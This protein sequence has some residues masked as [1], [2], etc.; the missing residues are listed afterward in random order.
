MTLNECFNVSN[1]V[2]SK[3]KIA[4]VISIL[5]ILSLFFGGYLS[6]SSSSI[7]STVDSV[8]QLN[9]REAGFAVSDNPL[10]FGPYDIPAGYFPAEVPHFLVTNALCHSILKVS[11]N[12]S[13][14]TIYLLDNSQFQE[15]QDNLPY[16]PAS[17]GIS[18]DI[19]AGLV[20][21]T[22]ITIKE[23]GD[24]YLAI[25]NH[26]ASVVQVSGEWIVDI[27]PPTIEY[28]LESMQV[29]TGTYRI[30]AAATDEISEID[31]ISLI[32][33][34][35]EI[36]TEDGGS[37]G[38]DWNTNLYANGE[39]NVTLEYADESNNHDS[40]YIIIIVS[41]T[42]LSPGDSELGT[43]VMF[44]VILVIVVAAGVIAC[45]IRHN[46]GKLHKKRVPLVPSDIG[47]RETWELVLSRIEKCL[48]GHKKDDP[49]S[50]RMTSLVN[51][52]R[53]PRDG[54]PLGFSRNRAENVI[55]GLLD[56]GLLYRTDL[57]VFSTSPKYEELKE[58]FLRG[59]EN[60]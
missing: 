22:G 60:T 4:F 55:W 29:V 41:N 18:V 13:G 37:L 28:N 27:W 14:V 42:E 58:K 23:N 38:Y 30:T 5:T 11:A 39:H 31:Y 9:C 47:P 19:P 32:V 59:L 24:Y 48:T 16:E 10:S 20:L 36:Y 56:A 17:Y 53:F 44:V 25:L 3:R 49:R 43:V 12:A 26:G 57:G 1:R 34:G 8:V 15:W 35:D 2:D 33:D 21:E 46:K 6:H 7:N 40:V 51:S 52:L 45:V 50:G 54:K